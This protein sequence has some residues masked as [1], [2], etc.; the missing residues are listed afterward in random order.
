MIVL[1][2]KVHYSS[3]VIVGSAKC[4]RV[5][6]SSALHDKS[7]NYAFHTSYEVATTNHSS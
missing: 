7:D 5:L 4:T 6:T 2:I 1:Y 3:M